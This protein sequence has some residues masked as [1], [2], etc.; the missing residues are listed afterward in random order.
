MYHRVCQSVEK[1]KDY[2]KFKVLKLFYV[3]SY[4]IS[5]GSGGQGKVACFCIRLTWVDLEVAF[6]STW[7]EVTSIEELPPSN[8]PVGHFLDC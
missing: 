6:K 8:L 4:D 2:E 5:M 3:L 7:E 1:F